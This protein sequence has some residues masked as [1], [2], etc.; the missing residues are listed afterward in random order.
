MRQTV[1]TAAEIDSSAF[2][3]FSLTNTTSFDDFVDPV[4]TATLREHTLSKFAATVEEN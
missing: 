1:G 2:H 4:E 3:S